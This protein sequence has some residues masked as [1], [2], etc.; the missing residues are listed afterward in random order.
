MHQHRAM[1]MRETGDRIRG[2]FL[3]CA[4][5]KQLDTGGQKRTVDQWKRSTSA[6]F[7]HATTYGTC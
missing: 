7:L 4:A 1:P 6:G 3:T 2:K 5:L